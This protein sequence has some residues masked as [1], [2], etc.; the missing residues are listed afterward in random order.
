VIPVPVLLSVAVGGLGSVLA[1]S[2]AGLSLDIYAQIGLVVLIALATKN[3]ILIVKFA[4]KERERGVPVREAAARG[5]HLRFRAVMM[6]SIAFVMGLVPLVMASGVAA[7]SRRSVGTT[8]FGGMLASSLIG[9][10]IVPMLYV[11]F[12]VARAQ[13]RSLRFLRVAKCDD[14][15]IPKSSEGGE[16]RTE[17]KEQPG[18]M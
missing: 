14:Q 4:K 7:L 3:G 6:T 17:V 1:I 10:F 9:I 13:V 12:E 15:C 8:V 16:G 11:A 18:Q 2:V 5:A